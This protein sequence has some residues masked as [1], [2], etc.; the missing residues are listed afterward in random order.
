[1]LNNFKKITETQNVACTKAGLKIKNFAPEKESSEYH[2]HTFTIHNKHILFRIAKKTPTK[3]G[4]FVTIWKRNDENSIAPYDETDTI[5]FVVIAVSNNNQIGEFIFT[6]DILLNKNI[7]STTD[8]EGKRAIRVYTPW[9]KVTSAQAA[10][11]QQWQQ[12]FFVDL[13]S[14][15]CQSTLKIKRL[16][17]NLLL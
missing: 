2:A 4:W 5:D 17:A 10:K 6:K 13:S 8:K 15:N 16:Y 3:T 14:P 7:F 12:Q 1:M 9:D 11:T